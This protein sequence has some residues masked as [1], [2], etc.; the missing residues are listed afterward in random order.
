MAITKK[1]A[2]PLRMPLFPVL[3]M[4]EESSQYQSPAGCAKAK[5]YKSR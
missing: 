1:P 2:P 3:L 4:L 5:E